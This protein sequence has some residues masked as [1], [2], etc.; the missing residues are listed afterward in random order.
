MNEGRLEGGARLN[1]GPIAEALNTGLRNVERTEP[2]G[3]DVDI[4]DVVI[5]E[6][7]PERYSVRDIL[8]RPLHHGYVVKLDCHEFAFET[9]ET[10]LKYIDEYLKDPSGTEEKWWKRELFK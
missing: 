8:I 1:G 2:Y 6:P 9:S 4:N 3:I 5:E 10:A 7:P